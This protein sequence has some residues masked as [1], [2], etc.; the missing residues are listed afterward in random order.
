[1]RFGGTLKGPHDLLKVQHKYIKN[2][3]MPKACRQFALFQCSYCPVK[4]NR[5]ANVEKGFPVTILIVIN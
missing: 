1:M 4:N 5:G 3:P 2:L